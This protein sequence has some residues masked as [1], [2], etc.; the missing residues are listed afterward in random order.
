MDMIPKLIHLCWFSG[1]EY[2]EDIKFCLDSWKKVLPDFQV[3]VW[4][5]E[6]ALATGFDFVKEAIS[7]KMWAFAADVIR[8][9]AVYHEG[10]VYMDSDIYV[11]KRFDEFMEKRCAF[12][13]EYIPDLYTLD[14]LDEQG[15]RLASVKYV[16]G[17]GVQ[18]ALFMSE[19]GNTYLKDLLDDYEGKHFILKDG[20]YNMSLL[21]PAVYALKAESYG[22]K[23]LN[24]EQ[25]LSD[26]LI[27]YPSLYVASGIRLR[28]EKNFAVHCIGHSWFYK[29]REQAIKK[30]PWTMRIKIFIY[31]LYCKLTG[32]PA[33]E[34]RKSFK[35]K[36]EEIPARS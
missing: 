1:D 6:M 11:Q 23:Y 27:I 22:Y 32:K 12:F 20:I 36:L 15:S 19:P 25:H 35:E 17:M 30:E 4:T 18:A 5:K 8:L 29:F 2:P 26:D 16:Q 13:Q 34:E 3:K 28:D 31:R 21:A 33:K 9:Y 14:E 7:A 24:V 10:G